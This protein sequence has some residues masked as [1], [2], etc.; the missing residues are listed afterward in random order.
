M[1]ILVP[2]KTQPLPSLFA[3]VRR[4]AESLP[5]PGSVSAQA[6]SHSPAAAFGRYL[7]FCASLPNPSTCPVPRPLCDATVSARDPSTRAIS[8]TQMA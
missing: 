2:F 1:N 7:F 4:L 5:L 8:S 6:A 3:V